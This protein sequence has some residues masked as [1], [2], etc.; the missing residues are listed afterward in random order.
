MI[1]APL[2]IAWIGAL[3]LVFFDGRRRSVGWTAL[4]VLATSAALA[5]R[6]AFHVAAAGPVEMTT[7]TWPVGIG[8]TLRADPLGVTFAV[9]S[10]AVLAAA[11]LYQIAAGQPTRRFPG[12]VLFMATGLTGVF[13]T[14][15]TFN[16][17]V[18]FEV[19]MTTA[20]A[21]A[22]EA[23][24]RREVRAALLFVTLNVIGSALFL[25]AV[26]GLYRATGSLEFRAVAGSLAGVDAPRALG[27]GALLLAAF[28]LKLGLFPF[29]GWLPEVYRDLRPEVAAIFSGALANIGSYGV[30]RFGGGLL[31]RELDD[32][33]RLVLALGA[34]SILY[35]SVA[36]IGARSANGVLA[37]SSIGQAGYVLMAA[38]LSSPAGLAAA[39]VYAVV[40][41]LNK[42][43]LFLASG[44]RGPV[45]QAAFAAGAF[46]LA[47][48]PPFAGF[49]AKIAIFRGGIDAGAWLPVGVLAAG[50]ILSLVYMFPA[51]QRTYWRPGGPGRPVP[52]PAGLVLAGLVLA[53]V[54]CGVAASP[55]LAVGDA[56]AAAL[57]GMR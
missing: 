25:M 20:F 16:F 24:E 7:G 21:L 49:T 11:L 35:G 27:I 33:S 42:T 40:L 50:S 48:V 9:V 32:A 28:G 43:L 54:A 44:L 53:V 1:V 38:A 23:R 18:F 4:A 19:A 5:V 22:A 6:L 2:F 29:H 30:L 15:D 56:A 34:A 57:A 14:G 31:A 55:L 45:A 36:A 3:V 47:G 51:F 10:L 17:Y 39:V 26:G 37:Y 46:S 41:T 13:L 8:I 12:L 52:L